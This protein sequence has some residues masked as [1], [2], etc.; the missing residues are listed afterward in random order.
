MNGWLLLIPFFAVRFLLPAGLNRHALQ[1]AADFAPMQGKERMAYYMYQISNAGL[2]F[3][4]FFLNVKVS[5]SIC[6]FLGVFFYLAGLFICAASIAAYCFPDR[7]G[8]NTNGIYRFSR[9]PMYVAYFIC[10]AGMALLTQSGLLFGILMIFQSSA[11]WIVL[12]EE[13]WCIQN[14]G[15]EYRQY[16]KKVR[17]YI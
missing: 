4:L 2:F 11:H 12:A 5:V 10:F 3:Y 17:R 8:L 16:M 14:F 7:K 1:R 13:R 15:E 9:N 6:F